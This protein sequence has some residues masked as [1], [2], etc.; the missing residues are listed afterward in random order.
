M[1]PVLPG[2]VAFL[3]WTVEM[4]AVPFIPDDIANIRPRGEDCSAKSF[5]NRSSRGQM[6]ERI[7]ETIVDKYI[8]CHLR[9]RLARPTLESVMWRLFRVRVLRKASDFPT[10][11]G[12]T[13]YTIAEFA[14]YLCRTVLVDNRVLCHCNRLRPQKRPP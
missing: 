8:L 10:S 13:S 7:L 3:G 2:L 12:I 4:V 9:Y 14:K 6:Y 1:S 11:N 5:A